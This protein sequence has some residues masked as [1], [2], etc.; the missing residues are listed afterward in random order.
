VKN[1]DIPAAQ[2]A[3]LDEDVELIRAAYPP[4][5]QEMFSEGHLTPV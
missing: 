1:F 3:Q 4:F 2:Q 5:D